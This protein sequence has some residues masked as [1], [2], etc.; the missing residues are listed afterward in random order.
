MNIKVMDKVEFKEDEL[1][2]LRLPMD[3]RIPE[4]F[5]VQEDV[6]S[7]EKNGIRTFNVCIK[8]KILTNKEYLESD[9]FIINIEINVKTNE[10]INTYQPICYRWLIGG[11]TFDIENIPYANSLYQML[12]LKNH[13][14][15]NE[16]SFYEDIDT[17]I[18]EFYVFLDCSVDYALV[19]NIKIVDELNAY[20]FEIK[21][22]IY[23]SIIEDE[24]IQ[25]NGKTT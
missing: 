17:M 3:L 16:L 9:S 5:F 11:D 1:T 18:E 14:L 23:K 7:N 12:V 19:E 24:Y 2:F 8:P 6:S 13:K 4:L 22:I 20:F 25:T 15:G 10:W 21:N